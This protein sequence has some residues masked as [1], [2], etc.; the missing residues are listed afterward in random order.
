MKC[1][2]NFIRPREEIKS[3]I[4]SGMQNEIKEELVSLETKSRTKNDE[5]SKGICTENNR[6]QEVTE[7]EDEIVNVSKKKD[8]E[9]FQWEWLKPSKYIVT[10]RV[11][12]DEE[13]EDTDE[14]SVETEVE[15]ISEMIATCET[16]SQMKNP[17]KGELTKAIKW[18]DIPFINETPEEIKRLQREDETLKTY[19]MK[20]EGT[21]INGKREDYKGNPLFVVKKGLLYKNY[22]EVIQD[23]TSTRLLIPKTLRNKVMKVA[24]EALLTA[25]QG[26]RKT[27][28]KICSVF[29]W[30]GIMSDVMRFVKSCEIC[31]NALGKQGVSKAP[32]GHLPIIEEPFAMICVDIVG[33]IQ[34]RTSAGNKYIL[35]VID[36][37][38]RYPEAVPMKNISTEEVV[39]K[40]F[41]IYCR[42][43]IPKR[44][45]T[46]RGG[47]FTSELLNEVNHLLMIRHTMS[48]PYHAQGNSVVERLNGTI[49]TTLKKLAAEKPKDWDRYLSPLMFA[50]RDSV[51]EGHGFT[52]FELLFG[53]SVRGPMK[54]LKELWTNENLQEETKDVYSYML[55]LQERIQETCKVAQ[56]EI[57]KM[58]RKNEKYYNK[59]AR[60]RKLEIGD[61]VLL[62]I[63]VKTD[64]LKLRWAG[65]FT[66]KEKVG[67]YDYR[68]EMEDGKIRVYHI[69]LMK[70]YNEREK[71]QHGEMEE[72][73]LSTIITVVNDSENGA[74]E[75][76]LLMLY[77]GKPKGTHRDVLI[78]P[79]LNDESK[80]ELTRILTHQE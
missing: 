63:P 62:M 6:E 67:D 68:I 11:A 40:L 30:P 3:E 2:G 37:A 66:V 36:M 76:E 46:D 57:A 77:N 34:P 32:L 59:R 21:T 58:Q 4:P 24:H 45:H 42:T 65:P 69:N 15:P 38:T 9:Y 26:I 53:R 52:P 78:N 5:E 39:D 41:D 61:K 12:E 44:I 23:K 25:H 19:W 33:P 54:I 7:R 22:K 60:Y 29:Y 79:T 8:E 73:I 75:D 28:D 71:E 35:T 47:Q 72:E 16:R 14:K 49:K 64:K 55:E 13:F 1:R 80:H 48:S 20:A 31:Q 27:Q 70:K 51:H 43:G 17:E 56:Q 18:K 50:L 74:E 10:K